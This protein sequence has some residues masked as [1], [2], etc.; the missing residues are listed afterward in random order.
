MKKFLILIM[1]ICATQFSFA[2]ATKDTTKSDIGKI[3]L[4]IV[5]PEALEGLDASQLSKIQSKVVQIV[6]ASGLGGSSLSNTFV[7][8]PKFAINDTSVA[9]G[10]M[11]N[12]TVVSCEFSL[13]I[14]ET[15]NNVLYSSISKTLKGSGKNQLT[16]L[17]NAI[18]QISTGD[19]VWKNFIETG[20]NKIIQYYESKTDDLIK[21]AEGLIKIEKF[22]DAIAL[23]LTVPEEIPSCYQK[24]QAKAIEAF[25][26][27]QEN[28]GSK[29]LAI[30]KIAFEKEDFTGGL[31]QIQLIDPATNAYKDANNLIKSY[32][33]KIAL[34]LLANAKIEFSKNNF[35]V[36]LDLIKRIDPSTTSYAE[37]VPLIAIYKDKLNNQ[38]LATAKIEFERGNF[39]QALDS[40]Q[41]IEAESPFFKEGQQLI[42]INQEKFCKQLLM[43][44]KS[45]FAL[46]DY[47]GATQYLNNINPDTS[48]YGD[49]QKIVKEIDAKITAE[50]KREIALR[51]KEYADEMQLKRETLNAIKEVA[52]E[53]AKN[54]PKTINYIGIIK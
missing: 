52:I 12:I 40:I 45:A 48:C 8:Y 5:L 38:L 1:F 24:V 3:S 14:K 20:K 11:E 21:K 4:S 46:K 22:E 44:A 39:E 9:E 28:K 27:L 34:V 51:Q 49:A 54:Q 35:Y 18:N 47:S 31:N 29:L 19:T 2:Q 17:N 32:K 30:A 50:E 6:T 36:A 25:K 26:A 10:G 13:Y 43:K 15:E 33:D 37:A 42:K 16:A 7:I 23:L 41:K 53:N